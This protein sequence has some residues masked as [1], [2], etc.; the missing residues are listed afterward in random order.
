MQRYTRG[1]HRCMQLYNILT[2]TEKN[3]DLLRDSS[4]VGEALS[5]D[6]EHLPGTTAEG[7]CGTV[8]GRVS[9]TKNDRCASH[10]RKSSLLARAHAYRIQ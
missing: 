9:S 4:D 6:N 3:T 10:L 2:Q 1:I 7:R 5:E 8:K